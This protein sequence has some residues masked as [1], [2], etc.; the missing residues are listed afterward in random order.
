LLDVESGESAYLSFDGRLHIHNKGLDSLLMAM[1]E[2][3]GKLSI[4]GKGRDRDKL[5]QDVSKLGL[6]KKVEIKGYITDKEKEI[7]FGNSSVF[8]LPSRYEGQGIV[9]L[10]AAAC[11][12]PVIVSDIPEL[13]YAVDAGFGISFRTG[14][15][16]DLA[17]KINL[18]LGNE[19]MRKEMG[20]RAREYAKDYTWDKIAELYE[21]YLMR[22]TEMRK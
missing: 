21:D 10:E 16:R 19:S 12:K 13:R 20:Q 18:L 15:A 11:G 5:M 2:V 14:D 22:V 1:K 7:F 4:A 8:I 9:V 6:E 3:D 17:S